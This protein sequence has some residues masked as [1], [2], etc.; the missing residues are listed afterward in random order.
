MR[1]SVARQS[2]TEQQEMLVPGTSRLRNH[3]PS[4]G[5]AFSG[6]CAPVAVGSSSAAMRKR[7]V[8]PRS[9]AK[10]MPRRWP[11]GGPHDPP[12][13]GELRSGMRRCTAPVYNNWAAG[14]LHRETGMD[15]AA[16]EGGKLRC[17]RGNGDLGE[18]LRCPTALA[19]HHANRP[20]MPV[21]RQFPGALMEHLAVDMARLFGGEKK[22]EGG[23]G[24]GPAA[25]QPLL[26]KCR[27]L[28][29][30]RRRHRAGHAGVRRR[31]DD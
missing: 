16:V 31:A 19:V 6:G 7:R 21:E 20:H 1:Y 5:S 8:I 15:S 17:E 11:R 28:R 22:R 10:P 14:S 3:G 2:A 27:R 9:I 12:A 29:V 25:A 24:G 13:P 26:T 18:H 4:A 30:L 23:D